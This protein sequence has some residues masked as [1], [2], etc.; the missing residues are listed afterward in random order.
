MNKLLILLVFLA[1]P[2]NA[3]HLRQDHIIPVIAF[4]ETPTDILLNIAGLPSS[5]YNL[6]KPIPCSFIG[7]IYDIPVSR[8]VVLRVLSCQPIIDGAKDPVFTIERIFGFS[9]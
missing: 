9:A 6:P 3:D 2:A 7:Y 5:C 8:G 1:F 4:C